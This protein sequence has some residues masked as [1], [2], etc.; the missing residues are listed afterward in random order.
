MSE[1]TGGVNPYFETVGVST[2][3]KRLP[4]EQVLKHPSPIGSRFVA[5]A[6]VV[7]TGERRGW[8]FENRDIR[9]MAPSLTTTRWTSVR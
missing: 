1:F 2:V 9:D 8:V 5:I 3:P 4:R 7:G 6:V